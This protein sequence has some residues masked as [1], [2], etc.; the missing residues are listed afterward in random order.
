MLML[1]KSMSKDQWLVSTGI[2]YV[3]QLVPLRLRWSEQANTAT[4]KSGADA[5]HAQVVIDFV[6]NHFATI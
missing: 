6:G 2:S 1:K 4:T 5:I 3:T